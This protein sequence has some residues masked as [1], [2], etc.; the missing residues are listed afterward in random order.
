M[1]RAFLGHLGYIGF[2]IYGVARGVRKAKGALADR[3]NICKIPITFLGRI[4]ETP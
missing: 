4:R 1:F 2:K 3:H